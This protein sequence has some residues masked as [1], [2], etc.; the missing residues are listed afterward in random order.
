MSAKIALSCYII[1]MSTERKRNILLIGKTGCGKSTIAN[2]ILCLDDDHRIFDVQQSYQAVTTK[3]RNSISNIRIGSSTYSI[4]VIDTI[5]FSDTRKSGAKSDDAIMKEI[6]KEMQ[7]RAPEGINLLIFVFKHGRFTNEERVVFDKIQQNF[8]SLIE[9]ISLLVITNCEQL[10]TEG[11]EKVIS[12]FR[13]DPLTKGF[14]TMMKKGIYAVGFPELHSLNP[15]FQSV[16]QQSMRNDIAPLH[17]II[18]NSSVWFLQREIKFDE[19]FW[20]Q[21]SAL[22]NYL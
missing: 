5:G 22:C 6:K 14:A 4:N 13:T 8:S 3:I 19:N 17:R 10:S 18:A 7:D 9:H 21:V 12:D 1:V 20:I 16:M 11:K 15:M 2:K